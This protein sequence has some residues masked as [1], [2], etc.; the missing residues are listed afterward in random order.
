MIAKISEP[1][2]GVLFAV[3][4]HL[5]WGGMAVYFNFLRGLHQTPTVFNRWPFA[6]Y[7]AITGVP[8]S[9]VCFSRS[10]GWMETAV[11]CDHLDRTCNLFGV[12]AACGSHKKPGCISRV[13]KFLN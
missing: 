9:R 4:A 10:D 11:V 6:I 12:N 8:H 2:K 1:N 5:F 3:I 7:L 13:F